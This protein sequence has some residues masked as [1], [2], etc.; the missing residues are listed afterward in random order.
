[1]TTPV[2]PLS[3]DELQELDNFM[4]YEVA[5]DE[6]MTLDTLDGYLYAIA[7]GPVVKRRKVDTFV[8]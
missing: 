7:I 5:C 2:S 8:T 6:S 3:D 1:M 4:L